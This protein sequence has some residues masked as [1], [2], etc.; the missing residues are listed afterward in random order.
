MGYNV[1]VES[2][3]LMQSQGKI[4]NIIYSLDDLKGELKAEN[5]ISFNLG[6]NYI[7]NS[8]FSF[9]LNIFRNTI[10]D[11]IDTRV[12]AN[13]T[14]GQNV[15][16]YYNLNNVFTQGLEFNSKWNPSNSLT[17]NSGFQLLYAKD[18]DAIKSFNNGEVYARKN[19]NSPA[20]QL[21]KKDYFGLFNRSRTMININ[22]NYDLFQE[23]IELN[24]KGKYRSKYGI[25]D[26]NYNNFLDSYDE[27]VNGYALID[28]T[29]PYTIRKKPF[30]RFTWLKC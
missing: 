19:P 16:S 28:F 27:F 5:S 1:A 2:I 17:I 23:N 6:F 30:L 8:E 25:I 9:D 21:K 29:L 7:L 26:S 20:F 11:L 10:K 13:K 3:S 12:I 18:S 22:I 15:F 4:S 24:L 14:N